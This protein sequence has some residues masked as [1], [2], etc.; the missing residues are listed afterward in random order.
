MHSESLYNFSPIQL[1]SRDS[2][3]ETYLGA[4]SVVL[5]PFPPRRVNCLKALYTVNFY[6]LKRS[7]H[8]PLPGATLLSQLLPSHSQS[9]QVYLL[10]VAILHGRTCT[11]IPFSA[12]FDLETLDWV[13]E[14]LC[15][16]SLHVLSMVLIT[17]TTPPAVD[18]AYLLHSILVPRP[19]PF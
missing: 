17:V 18:K 19:P 10:M 15:V 11:D 16:N 8:T 4:G 13:C 12:S 1:S 14:L 9:S 7:M 2:M 5:R 3:R 6:P